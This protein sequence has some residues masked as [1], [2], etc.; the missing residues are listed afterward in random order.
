MS[1]A[2][3]NVLVFV[4]KSKR[5]FIRAM[6][7]LEKWC[8]KLQAQGDEYDL[9]PEDRAEAKA[10]GLELHKA[11]G[12][13]LMQQVWYVVRIDWGAVNSSRWLDFLW[14]EVGDWLT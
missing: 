13:W 7:R 5:Q 3:D 10:I 2:P 11:G 1:A 6:A 12:L 9:T 8:D 4:G 14:H